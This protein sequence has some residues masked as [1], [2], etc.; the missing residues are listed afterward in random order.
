M[1]SSKELIPSSGHIH[2]DSSFRL[3]SVCTYPGLAKVMTWENLQNQLATCN[4]YADNI[5]NDIHIQSI[6][7]KY[8]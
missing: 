2:K 3:T 4:T 7:E 5:G 8:I 6:Q 1:L